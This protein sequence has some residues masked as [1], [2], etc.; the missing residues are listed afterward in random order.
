MIGDI[1][2]LGIFCLSLWFASEYYTYINNYAFYCNLKCDEDSK[3]KQNNCERFD[4]IE[5]KYEYILKCITAEQ[6][7][8]L[9]DAYQYLKDDETEFLIFTKHYEEYDLPKI[10]NYTFSTPQI[11]VKISEDN[12]DGFGAKFYKTCIDVGLLVMSL[13]IFVRFIYDIFYIIR[14]NSNFQSCSCLGKLDTFRIFISIITILFE[15]FA[16]SFCSLLYISKFEEG[17]AKKLNTS[18]SWNTIAMYTQLLVIIS[19]IFLSLQIII[20]VIQKLN[21]CNCCCEYTIQFPFFILINIILSLP[22]SYKCYT[23]KDESYNYFFIF[24]FLRGMIY[25]YEL[26]FIYCGVIKL[27]KKENVFKIAEMNNAIDENGERVQIRKEDAEGN[28][29][30][31]RNEE[32]ER[33]GDLR[34]SIN[35]EREKIIK[36]EEE[37]RERLR[38]IEEVERERIRKI[39]EEEVERLRILNEK[40]RINI[41]IQIE[42]D[43]LKEIRLESLRAIKAQEEFRINQEKEDERIKEEKEKLEEERIA[44]NVEQRNISTAKA[45]LRENEEAVMEY[46][47]PI[48]LGVMEDPVVAADGRTYE[49]IA[50]TKWL[51]THGTSPATNL[52]LSST[53]LI[54]NI[55]L[56]NLIAVH[57]QNIEENK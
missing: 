30:N 29:I 42:N 46:S 48:T 13:L 28:I 56:R 50:I 6:E 39:K 44:I 2:R 47:C 1:L 38:I 9:E 19:S 23:T 22:V 37:E 7:L 35:K 43:R 45:K 32:E 25:L 5:D 4:I 40:K 14:I 20:M 31:I 10:Q 26:L 18:D 57:N 55:Q 53:T 3:S 33:E 8:T 24:L 11:I 52:P 36:Q 54:P 17:R 21:I 15:G 12:I 34:E 41:E 49:R 27:N 16:I 51:E